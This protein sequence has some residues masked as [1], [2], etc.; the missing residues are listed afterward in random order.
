MIGVSDTATGGNQMRFGSATIVNG[1]VTAALTPQA[2]VWNVVINGVARAN[3][4]SI[5]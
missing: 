5:K 2:K 4:F 1:A 3:S